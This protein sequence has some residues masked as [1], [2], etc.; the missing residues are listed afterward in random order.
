[1]KRLL[2]F[3]GVTVATLGFWAS[4]AAAHHGSGDWGTRD[5]SVSGT[6]FDPTHECD[7]SGVSGTSTDTRAATQSEPSNE[8]AE[9]DEATEPEA[10]VKAASFGSPV[11]VK[12]ELMTAPEL[13]RDDSRLL[14]ASAAHTAGLPALEIGALAIVVAAAIAGST[15]RRRIRPTR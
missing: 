10:E 4:P 7:H 6:Q 12:P 15:A 8:A 1:M 9:A 11:V 3:L 13:V 2:V 5:P 14:T